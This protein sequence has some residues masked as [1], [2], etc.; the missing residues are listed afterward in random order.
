MRVILVPVA[1]RPECARALDVAF[2]MGKR[3]G[4][5]V[6]G[7]H[8]RPH[9]YSEVSLSSA[10]ADKAWRR[11]STKKA[12]AAAKSLYERLADR[13]GYD[14]VRRGREEPAALWSEK[15]GSPDI[16]MGIH[17][18][19]SDLVVVSRPKKAGG[20]A[21]MFLNAALLES[22]RPV[23]ILPATTRRR[24]GKHVVIGWNQ[25]AEVAR[26]VSAAMPVLQ[27]ANSVTIVTCGAEDRAG[28]KS[29]HL[30]EYLHHWGVDTRHIEKPGKRIEPELLDAYKKA[31]GDLLVAGAYSRSR[32]REKVFGGTT[33]YLLRKARVPV[34]MQHSG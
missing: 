13:H 4:A 21:D 2:D 7:C 33:E 25:S 14:V 31:G 32:W 34:L 10:F 22:T 30:A 17:G 11:K 18:P 19:V 26:T 12:P 3:L 1:D 9:R 29:S 23:L 20:V 27:A 28:P 16:L 24:I 5:S 15:V 8:M 6:S